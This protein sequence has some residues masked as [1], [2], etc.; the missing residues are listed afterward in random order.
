M[1][2]HGGSSAGSYLA[3]PSYLADP[4]SLIPSHF[5]VIIL[6]KSV[7]VHQLPWLVVIIFIQFSDKFPPFLWHCIF[8][9]SMR[10]YVSCTKRTYAQPFP[11]NTFFIPPDDQNCWVARNRLRWVVCS[12]SSPI[13]CSGNWTQYPGYSSSKCCLWIVQYVGKAVKSSTEKVILFLHSPLGGDTVSMLTHSYP[14]KQT[15][16]E[17]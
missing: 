3:G 5:A 16:E 6:L 1:V 13:I 4:T 14:H 10:R 8:Q 17:D 2:G 9:Q 7:S 11:Q 15:P 12:T